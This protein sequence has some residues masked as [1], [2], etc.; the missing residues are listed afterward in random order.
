MA[1]SIRLDP[2][3]EQ[4]LDHLAAPKGRSKAYYLR[5][6]VT[7][8]LEDFED[9]Y[10]ASATMK[11]VRKGQEPLYGLDG[12][13][14]QLGLAD[15]G[16]EAGQYGNTSEYVRELIRKD[17]AARP[18]APRLGRGGTL[19]RHPH[20]RHV[21]RLGRTPG[22]RSRRAGLKPLVLRA[23]AREDRRHQIRFHRYRA[24]EGTALRLAQPSKRHS[25]SSYGTPASARRRSASQSRSRA[26]AGGDSPASR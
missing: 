19:K 1:T 15:S 3:V 24:G 14:R 12:V 13:E 9:F 8:S 23:K 25:I 18:A 20:A 21:S 16:V 22:D 26:C 6:L 2:A 4:R 5:E 17:Q 7:N 11:R 10:L